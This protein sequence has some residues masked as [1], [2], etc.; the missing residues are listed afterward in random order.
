MSEE[1]VLGTFGKMMCADAR[2]SGQDGFP[3]DQIW[4]DF[5]EQILAHLQ[6]MGVLEEFLPM[7]RG[8]VSQRDGAL[9]EAYVSYFFSRCGFRLLQYHPEAVPGKPMDLEAQY[10]L[11]DSFYVEVKGPSWKGEVPEGER[12]KRVKLPKHLDGE[13]G[14][15]NPAERIEYVIDNKLLHKLSDKK[16][17]LVAIVPNL[18]ISPYMMPQELIDYRIGQALSKETH[19]IIAGVFVL[20]PRWTITEVEFETLF[21]E[22]PD[23]LSQCA[24]PRVV[25]DLLQQTNE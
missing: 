6:E 17:N 14:S 3:S 11:G 18:F 4:A 25:T 2:W 24:L 9:A 13:G 16:P 20:E 5:I 15:A 1:V 21:V 7:L 22:N 23:V 10:G 8:T 19:E 12:N